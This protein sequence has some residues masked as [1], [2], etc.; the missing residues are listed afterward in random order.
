MNYIGSKYKLLPFIKE[1]IYEVVGKDLST[2][3]F[4]D[5]FAGTAVVGR[6]FKTEVKQIISND[7]EYYS[8][9]LNKNYIGNH[10]PFEYQPYLYEL[11]S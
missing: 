11:N 7:I 5:L 4:C 10:I 3:I 2:Q 1:T 6:A 9:V 8:Y